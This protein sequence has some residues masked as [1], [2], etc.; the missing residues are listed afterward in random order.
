VNSPDAVIR[1]GGSLLRDGALP[2]VLPVLRDA[3][4]AGKR[5]LLV[6]G[7]GP[8]ADAVRTVCRTHPCGDAAAHWMAVLAMDQHAH[9]LA[10]LL[11]GATLVT[12]PPEPGTSPGLSVL[13]PYAWLRREDPLPHSWEVTSDSIAAWV[14]ARLRVPLLVL[15]KSVD[16]IAGEGGR[17]LPHIDRDGL[18]G[19]PE[20]DGYFARAFPPATRCWI[21]NGRHPERLRHLLLG[22]S[23]RGTE[24]R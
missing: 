17:V 8:F 7:G 23:T 18:A 24:V 16:G 10:D 6:P 11:P 2:P 21:V 3:A 22:G 13:A 5:L 12:A 14:A 1:V 15:V 9:L 20:V 19:R 4:A